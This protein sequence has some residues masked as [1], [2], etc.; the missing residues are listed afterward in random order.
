MLRP[1]IPFI[2]Y[3]KPEKDKPSVVKAASLRSCLFRYI[4][5]GGFPKE[6]SP[7]ASTTKFVPQAVTLTTQH[8]YV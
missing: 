8:E 1:P 3:T 4:F 6:R 2:H 5:R 7:L